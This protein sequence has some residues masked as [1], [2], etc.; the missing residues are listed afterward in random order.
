MVHADAAADRRASVAGDKFVCE[1]KDARGASGKVA[2]SVEDASGKV[3]F[4]IV[5]AE[6]TPPPAAPAEGTPPPA[7]P[8]EP[9]A[10]APAQ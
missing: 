2:V 1:A 10:P 3:S 9:G 4:A 5:P 6:G 8:A 7:L